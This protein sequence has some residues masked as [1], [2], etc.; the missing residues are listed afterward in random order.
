MKTVLIQS[1]L[2]EISNGNELIIGR[3]TV[4]KFMPS[5]VGRR[6]LCVGITTEGDVY[7]R[8]LK[9]LNGSFI[10]SRRIPSDEKIVVE[11][12]LTAVC[13]LAF[14]FGPKVSFLKGDKQD[15]WTLVVEPE[16]RPCNPR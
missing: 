7:F 14:P 2:G 5:Y 8:D 15:S 3:E 13:R 4:E 11:D 9:S 10:K 1:A 16:A 12:P 6:H